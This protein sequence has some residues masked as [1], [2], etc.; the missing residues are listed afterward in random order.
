[1]NPI[2]QHGGPR[3]AARKA[4]GGLA[5]L[6]RLRGALFGDPL[7]ALLSLGVLALLAWSLPALLRWAVLEAQFSPD[8]NACEALGHRGA[9]WG[10]VVEKARFILLGRYPA[11]QAWCPILAALLIIGGWLGTAS[12]RLPGVAVAA[13]LLLPPLLAC[14]LLGGGFAGL[15]AVPTELWGGLPLTLLLTGAGLAGALP[16]GIAIAYG[17][18]SSLPLL[19]ALLTAGVELARGIPLVAALFMASFMLPLFFPEGGGLDMLWRVLIAIVLFAAAY[20]SEIVRG[21]LQAF[22]DGQRDGAAAL[23]LT[24]WQT[25]RWIV[26][27]QVLRQVAPS[28]AN[29][30]IALFKDTSLVTVVSLYELTGSLGLAL[31]GDAQWR[32]FYLEAWLFI[33]AI[34]W[35]GCSLIARIARL[36]AR[37]AGHAP[38]PSI[39]AP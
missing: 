11:E 19:R 5:D 33:A 22:P 27:P 31:A 25:E 8:V 39:N 4:G 23:G 32:P 2:L 16:L 9:C 36:T 10:V 3:T 34:Y 15:E 12:G 6:K 35:V 38:T 37:D 28:L 1:M 20:L 30:G 24:P 26:L 29:S 7:N 18:R 21:G 14:A 13:C 17:R